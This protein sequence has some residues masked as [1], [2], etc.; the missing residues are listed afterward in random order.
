MIWRIRKV[1]RFKAQRVT[2]VINLSAFS[3]FPV[4]KISSVELNSGLGGKYFE[5][6]PGCRLFYFCGKQEMVSRLP[7]QYPVVVVTFAEFQLLVILVDSRANSVRLSEIKRGTRDIPEFACG[8]QSGIDG[9]EAICI[10]RE[11]MIENVAFALSLQI[12]I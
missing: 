12:E 1:L 6:T 7:V 2:E 5:R 3:G 10:Q 11:A 4:Q 9:R 8:N